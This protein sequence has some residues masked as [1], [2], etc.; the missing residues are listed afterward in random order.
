MGEKGGECLWRNQLTGE[1]LSGPEIPVRDV[2][3]GFPVALL[4]KE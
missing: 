1:A 4:Y 3:A 2:L